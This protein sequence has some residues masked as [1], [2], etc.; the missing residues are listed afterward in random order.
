MKV[1]LGL[2]EAEVGNI[3][4][5]IMKRY[6]FEGELID[7]LTVGYI[8]SRLINLIHFTEIEY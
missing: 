4:R 3:H 1:K 5:I 2:K 6:G 7:E 8:E